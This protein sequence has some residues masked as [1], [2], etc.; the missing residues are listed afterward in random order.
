MNHKTLISPEEISEGSSARRTLIST[1]ETSDRSG[2]RRT[3][4]S[5]DCGV[6]SNPLRRLPDPVSFQL[7]QGECIAVVGP[8]GSGKSTLLKMITGGFYLREGT[9]R[10]DLDD[11]SY[12]AIRFVEFDNAYSTTETQYY[13]Q[14]RWQAFEREASPLA[15]ELLGAAGQEAGEGWQQRLFEI[16]NIGPLLGKEI[17]TLSSGELRRFS[18]ARA[19]LQ[20][21]QVLV[22]ESPFI[23]LDP[24][25]RQVLCYLLEQVLNSLGISIIMT[26]TDPDRIPPVATH[27][28]YMNHGRLSAKMS[29]SLFL[30]TGQKPSPSPAVGQSQP[31]RETIDYSTRSQSQS[32][33]KPV[34]IHLQTEAISAQPENRSGHQSATEVSIGHIDGLCAPILPRSGLAPASED[35]DSHTAGRCDFRVGDDACGLSSDTI[36][37]RTSREA[38]QFFHEAEAFDKVVEMRNINISYG[39]RQIFRDLNW[40]VRSGER[41]NVTGPNGSGK[42]TLLSLVNADNPRAY[43]LDITLFDRRRGTG[44]SIWDIKRHI[45]YLS[46]EMH[47]SFRENL[48]VLDIV[49]GGLGDRFGDRVPAS[50]LGDRFGD[51]VP[52]SGLGD[53]FGDRVPASGLGSGDPISVKPGGKLTEAQTDTDYR[54]TINYGSD[55]QQNPNNQTDSLQPHNTED[56][57]LLQWLRL[58]GAE[59]LAQRSYLTLSSGEQRYILLIRAFVKDPDLLILDEPFQGLDPALRHRAAAVINAFCSA[60][61]KTLIFVT[62]YLDEVP[63]VVTHTLQL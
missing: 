35:P 55:L 49:R 46:S 39:E 6:I 17:I 24:P 2:A 59:H 15:G 57:Y 10:L 28:Y 11:E 3:L 20:R 12:R 5:L 29:A 34:G 16:L 8:V 37:E 60:K 41:W 23:G 58:F 27:V 62:H 32:E 48:P 22:L 19:L 63:G 4:I 31:Q 61:S 53:R 9:L 42:S 54:S 13:H 25:T 56:D 47:S 40:T 45:G 30:N 44:E 36:A 43:S 50:G 38:K 18:I 52:A 1:E 26:L 21:P 14:Q 51:R 7:R 33:I